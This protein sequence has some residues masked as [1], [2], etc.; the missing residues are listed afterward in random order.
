MKYIAIIFGLLGLTACQSMGTILQS[1]GSGLSSAANS[2]QVNC[3]TS[4]V[5]SGDT[6]NYYTSCN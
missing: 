3:N 5:K 4:G 6:F 2:K 1:G